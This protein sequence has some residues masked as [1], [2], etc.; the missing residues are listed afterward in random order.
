MTR[1][2][3]RRTL[4]RAA[5][6]R[7]L[8]LERS[9]MPVLDAVERLV[10]IQ[11]QET[12]MPYIGL[13]TRLE[14]FRRDDLTGLLYDRSAVRSSILRGTQ[15]M[16]SAADYLWMRPLVEESLLR[17]R[18]AAFG[19]ATRGWDLDEL[20]TE[21]RRLLAGRTLTRPQLGRALAERW[22]DRDPLA[23]GWSAQAL[24][25]VVHPPPSGTWNT[26]GATPFALAEEWIGRPLSKESPDRL[27]RRY[28][29]AFG[30]ASVKDFQMWSGMRRMDA[31][32]EELRPSLQTYRDEDGVELFD[33]PGMP[34]PDAGVPAP[35]R[36]LP[37]FDNLILAYADRSRIMTD[38]QRKAVC[39]GA[40]TKPSLLV[41]GRVHGVWTLK[42][43]RKA[44]RA[45]LTVELLAPLADE[46]PVRQEAARLLAFAADGADHVLRFTR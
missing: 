8:L 34:L 43:D 29:A 25:S 22:P 12:N 39:V 45:E 21:A 6:E 4:N 38:E 3:D 37:A 36:F 35:V 31:A 5:L 42:H 11:A 15:H 41:D 10:A 18:Q 2:L 24:V 13:W 28:L 7:Q 17:G 16:A 26:G 44:G 23:L 27:I 14:G 1:T 46:E 33:L 32:F 20:A 40:L 30:P 19:S 9:R